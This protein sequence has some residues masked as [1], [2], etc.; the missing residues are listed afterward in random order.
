MSH[1]DI[2]SPTSIHHVGDE[3]PTYSSHVESMS[4]TIV[5]DGGGMHMMKN[6]RRVR[7]YPRFICRN[8]EGNHLTRLYPATIGQLKAWFS[9]RSPSNSKSFVVSP[10]SVSSFF[11]ISVMS[12]Q[13]LTD[14]PLTLGVDASPDLVVSHPSQP[15]VVSMQSSTD[16]T[17]IFYGDESHGLT[18][19]H[20]VQPTI[21][22]VVVSMQFLVNPSL[23]LEDDASFTH[24]IR[25]SSTTTF[26]QE[27][28]VLSLQVL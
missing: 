10:E 11:E 28:I 22:E 26:E 15:M 5:N 16:T 8:Y 23:P 3:L 7:C 27:I 6:P 13:Y 4:P 12:M 25:I 2:T 9:P 19:M 1:I 18:V 21:E 14:T 24:F 20:T 17:P